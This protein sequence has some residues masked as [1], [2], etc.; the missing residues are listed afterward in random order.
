MTAQTLIGWSA[1]LSIVAA[2]L[3]VLFGLLRIG[4]PNLLG[5]VLN[6]LFC[7]AFVFAVIRL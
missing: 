7:V 1:L 3:L 6:F 5:W 2:V 4:G